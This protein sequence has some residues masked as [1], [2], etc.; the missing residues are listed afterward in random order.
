MVIA[1]GSSPLLLRFKWLGTETVAVFASEGHCINGFYPLGQ[2][3]S[4]VHVGADGD[5]E[6]EFIVSHYLNVWCEDGNL[7]IFIHDGS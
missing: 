6:V 4:E 7:W 2:I 3:E 5:R 1:C